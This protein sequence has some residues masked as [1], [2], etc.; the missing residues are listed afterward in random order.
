MFRLPVRGTTSSKMDIC[1][2]EG[3]ERFVTALVLRLWPQC[4]LTG[5]CLFLGRERTS[6]LMPFLFF[7]S[8]LKEIQ[9]AFISVLSEN[10]GR[11]FV[12][13]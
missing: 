13:T 11:L 9:S 10:D 4:M 12:N 7:Q 8:H 3:M 6:V 1:K 2:D 5:R